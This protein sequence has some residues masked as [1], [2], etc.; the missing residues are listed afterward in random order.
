MGYEPFDTM[1]RTAMLPGLQ[2]VP[3]PMFASLSRVSFIPS[4][5]LEFVWLI[6]HAVFQAD[7]TALDQRPALAEVQKSLC[8]GETLLSFLDETDF[9]VLPR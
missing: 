1:S 6:P 5:L 8:L 2:S 3:G 9:I 4:T 7:G